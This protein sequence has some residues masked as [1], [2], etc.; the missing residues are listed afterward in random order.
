MPQTAADRQT[1]VAV[2]NDR[3]NILSSHLTNGLASVH[4][5]EF[6]DTPANPIQSNRGPLF[7]FLKASLP[8]PI[9]DT[10]KPIL[11]S[12]RLLPANGTPDFMRGPPQT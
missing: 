11:R 1:Y 3:A 2:K 4:R 8:Q 6:E 5:P 10:I 9:K 7:R 12:V